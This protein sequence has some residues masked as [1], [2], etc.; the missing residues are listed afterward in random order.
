[1][2]SEYNAVIRYIVTFVS[3]VPEMFVVCIAVISEESM[4]FVYFQAVDLSAISATG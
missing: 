3:T 4:N 2:L 1:M